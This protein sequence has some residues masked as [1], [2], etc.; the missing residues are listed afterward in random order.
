MDSNK[1]RK[2]KNYEEKYLYSNNFDDYLNKKINSV[3]KT[4]IEQLL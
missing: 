2:N 4:D 3:Y 1:I